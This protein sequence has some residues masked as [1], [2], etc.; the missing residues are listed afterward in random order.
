LFILTLTLTYS[1]VLLFCFSLTKFIQIRKVQIPSRAFPIRS[2]SV[3]KLK[4]LFVL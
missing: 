2:F 4:R 3:L 1:Y